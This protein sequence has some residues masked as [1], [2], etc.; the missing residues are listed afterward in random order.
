MKRYSILLLAV[1]LLAGLAAVGAEAQQAS[2]GSS[3]L[4][5][6]FSCTGH[7]KKLAEMAADVLGADLYE[8]Q[9]QQPYT[10]ADLNYNDS[11]SRTTKE[12]N[13]T[14]VRP[15]IGS[16]KIKNMDQYQIIF[17]AFPIWWGQAPRIIDTFL[18]SYDFSG[19]TIVPFCT[20]MS[21]GIGSSAKN[22][23]NLTN[24]KTVWLDGTRLDSSLSRDNMVKWIKSLKLKLTVK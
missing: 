8:I 3:V 10:D 11:S 5:V 21:S 2:S 16:E 15:A 7:T 6:Y 17:L 24:P 4:V 19:K 13:D 9:A 14:S 12:M 22:L 1:L 18:E 20:S 23:H